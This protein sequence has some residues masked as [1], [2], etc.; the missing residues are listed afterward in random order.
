M[1]ESSFEPSHESFTLRLF[2]YSHADQHEELNQLLTLFTNNLS[3]KDGSE[4]VNIRDP[5]GQT[6]LYTAVA[7]QSLMCAKVLLEHGADP[8]FSCSAAYFCRTPL[9]FCAAEGSSEKIVEL[10]LNH[11]AEP[12]LQDLHG[13]TCLSLAKQNGHTELESLMLTAAEQHDQMFEMLV[14]RKLVDSFITILNLFLIEFE[15]L[16]LSGDYE[17]AKT[18][19][20]SVKNKKQTLLRHLA[21]KAHSLVVQFVH[22]L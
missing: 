19:L 6:P 7:S 12:L 4:S 18:C 2:Q 10:L 11:G 14:L 1:N 15:S 17:A 21:R 13:E 9:H 5:S 3:N 20:N 22:E 8:N 16:L